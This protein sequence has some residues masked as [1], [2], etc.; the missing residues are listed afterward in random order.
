[1]ELAE[2][3]YQ[4]AFVIASAL[5]EADP[6]DAQTQEYLL[7]SYLSQDNVFLKLGRTSD[8][9]TKFEHGLKI[10][11]ELTEADPNNGNNQLWL[12]VFCE[13]LG[14][15]LSDQGRTEDALTQFEDCLKSICM[16]AEAD[17]KNAQL[18]QNLLASQYELGNGELARDNFETAE[19]HFQAGIAVLDKMI[20]REQN[21][22]ASQRG[23][24]FLEDQLRS[25]RIIKTALGDWETLLQLADEELP[26]HLELRGIEC[27]KRQRFAEAEQATTKLLE[28]S[29]A[30]SAQLY[31]AARVFSLCAAAIKAE[32]GTELTTD[33]TTKR[34]QLIQQSPASL[35]LAIDKGWNDFAHMQ[36]DSD[37][38]PLHD[39]PEFKALIPAQTANP[40]PVPEATPAEADAKP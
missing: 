22:P 4:R 36:Q 14:T 5:A 7:H 27:C 9:M 31:N 23:K 6:S 26:K 19:Q 15:A 38:A 30:T 8:A 20:E 37:L 18:Q 28:L 32:E 39:L 11:R 29:N 21:I 24:D 40:E 2:A 1:M 17:P 35:K 33:R 34:Q 25:A 13:R 10:S 12:A 16:L 3:Y